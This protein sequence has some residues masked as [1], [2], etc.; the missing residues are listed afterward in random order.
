MAPSHGEHFFVGHFLRADA[1]EVAT[2][3]GELT[4]SCHFLCPDALKVAT[5]AE[6]TFLRVTFCAWML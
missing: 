5:G 1:L 3:T 2:G 4:Y 6:N